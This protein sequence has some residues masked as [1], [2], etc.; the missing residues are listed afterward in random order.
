MGS[1]IVAALDEGRNVPR[2][3]GIMA[4]LTD[5]GAAWDWPP[6]IEPG[7]MPPEAIPDCMPGTIPAIP[8]CIPVAMP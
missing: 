3:D 4:A 1:V 2:P 6:V 8:D 7:I 5:A